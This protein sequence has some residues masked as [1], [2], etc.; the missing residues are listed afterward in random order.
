MDMKAIIKTERLV[1]RQW[2]EDDLDPLARLNT[3]SQVMEFF[4]GPLT[5]EESAARLEVYSKHIHDH[6]WGLWAVSAPSVSDFIGWI[7]LWPIG[8][9]AH[10]TPATEVGWRLLPEFWGL[11]YATEGARASIQYGFEILKLDEIVSIT[12]PENIRSRRIMEKIGMHRDPKDDFDHPRFPEGY[13]LRRHVL[14]RINHQEWRTHQKQKDMRPRHLH[15]IE[16]QFA[17]ANSSKRF[18]LHQWFEQKHIKEWMHGVGLQN[19]LNGL[20]KFFRNES[21][22]TYWIAYDK[23]IPFAFLITSPEG[24]DAIT[25]D[26]FICDVNYLG[27]GL[28]APMI[29]EFLIRQFPNVKRILIDPEATNSRA[30]HVNQKVG[31]K[32]I[33]EFIASWHPVLHYQMELQMKDLSKNND[34]LPERKL[35]VRMMTL[36]KEREIAKHFRQKH[37]FDRVPIQDPY[38]WTF[39]H[40]DHLHFILYEGSGVVGYAHIQLWPDHRA[41][42]RIIVI[43]E[44]VRGQGMGK[45]LMDFC[46]RVDVGSPEKA[47]PVIR[48]GL[49]NRMIANFVKDTCELSG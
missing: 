21:N 15:T 36:P 5:R 20:E 49:R 40:K 3:D 11:G 39:D 10:F 1:L 43:D 18:M 42:I 45:Y 37:F 26:L 8:F 22:T 38:L 30:I 29:R 6:G 28:A 48:E 7:G 2:R 14:Y 25:L 44:K 33:G 23:E 47:D 16:F 4:P 24:N 46:E 17:P 9:D 34:A 31:F 12:V 41:A 32:I 13:P 35:H 27:K 19:T